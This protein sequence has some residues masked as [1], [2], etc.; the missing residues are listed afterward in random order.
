MENQT[1]KI[2]IILLRGIRYVAENEQHLGAKVLPPFTVIEEKF[3]NVAELLQN[4]RAEIYSGNI[5]HLKVDEKFKTE[6][7]KNKPLKL[8]SGNENLRETISSLTTQVNE[9]T[10]KIEEL[11]KP[12]K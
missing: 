4:G 11:S 3:G 9:L 8:Q 6:K 7:G 10:A 5:P 2:K 1:K 12:K